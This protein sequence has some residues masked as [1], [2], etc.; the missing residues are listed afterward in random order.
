MSIIAWLVVGVI[1]GF[2]AHLIM[3]GKGSI[4]NDL[5]LGVIG[6][7]VGGFVTG[8]LTGQDYTT[9]INIATIVVSVIGACIVIA[10]YR[11]FS[12]QRVRS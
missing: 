1:A 8:L 7:I 12:G 6:A 10:L 3:G 4:I 2:L 11:A 9:G 5:V